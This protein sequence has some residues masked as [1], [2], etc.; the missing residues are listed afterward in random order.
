MEQFIAN[1]PPPLNAAQQRC[2]DV[3]A[4]QE[5][6]LALPYYSKVKFFAPRVGA[7]AGPFTWTIGA[8][9]ISNAFSYGIG[10]AK[11]PAGFIA[12]DGPATGSDTN[13]ERGSQTISG[14]LLHITGIA[15]SPQPMG[16]HVVAAVNRLRAHDYHVMAAIS[17]MTS[18]RLIMNSRQVYLLGNPL[19]IPGAG[20]LAG[21][22]KNLSGLHAYSGDQVDVQF[23]SN[24]VAARA[25][26]YAIPEGIFW[27]P[28]G[29]R[30]SQLQ[31]EF[32]IDR[33]LIFTSGGD[34]DNAAANVVAAAGVSAWT[35]P[36]EIVSE[37]MCQLIGSVV[38]PRTRIT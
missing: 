3:V 34:I 25:N 14:E 32:R 8:G 35:Y 31:L 11:V 24:G 1:P 27:M 30:D 36:L 13:L 38:G 5:Y 28:Q 7:G 15:V 19:M 10:E 16:S 29:S 37:W 20:G 23:G 2:A 26:Y 17:S 22:G 9:T 6:Q 21:S 12:D 33:N 4:N 18:L